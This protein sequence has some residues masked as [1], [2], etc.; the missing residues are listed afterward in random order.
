LDLR[1]TNGKELRPLTHKNGPWLSLAGSNNALMARL[2]RSIMLHAPLGEYQMRF[3]PAEDPFCL[4]CLGPRQ[5]VETREHVL[6]RCR[7]LQC[8]HHG[9]L[10]SLSWAYI[11]F[12]TDN[13]RVLSLPRP[14]GGILGKQQA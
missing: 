8:S 7:G 6:Q 12:L 3:F 5:S 13:P 1:G 14:K 10:P 11:K 9:E 4:H 2:V